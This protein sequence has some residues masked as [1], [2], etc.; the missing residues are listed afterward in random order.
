MGRKYKWDILINTPKKDGR[1]MGKIDSYRDLV[2]WQRAMELAIEVYKLVKKLPREETYGLS[3]QMRRAVVSIASNIAE[4][5]S[6]NSVKDY[7]HYL[8]IARGSKSEL[9]TQLLMCV[10]IG[11]LSETDISNSML[12]LSEIGKMINTML[13]KFLP[14]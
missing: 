11:Y 14:K 4:G 6:R 5:Q 10:G 13:S 8:V 2:V 3:D 9:E 7:A 1:N 12:M